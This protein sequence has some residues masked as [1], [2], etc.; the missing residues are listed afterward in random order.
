MEWKDSTGYSRDEP[1]PRQPRAWSAKAG[2]FRLVV[3]KG[4]IYHPG[5]WVMHVHPGVLDCYDMKLPDTAPVGDV[6]K[7][8]EDICANLLRTALEV[9]EA[10]R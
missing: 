5:Q 4:H 8:A 6:H 10:K 9:L 3:T 7:C 1:T 2:V